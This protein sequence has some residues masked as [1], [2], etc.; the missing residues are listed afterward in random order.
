M[1]P[2]ILPMAGLPP[3]E[4]GSVIEVPGVAETG[5]GLVPDLPHFGRSLAQGPFEIGRSTE[6]VAQLIDRAVLCG[7]VVNTLPGAR[8]TQQLLGKLARTTWFRGFLKRYWESADADIPSAN[9]DIVVAS[10]GLS[11][12]NGLDKSDAPTLFVTGFKELPFVCHWAAAL[13][14]PTPNGV[15]R[16]AIGMRHDWP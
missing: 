1:V 8:V 15:E 10:A 2:I 12:P 7:S 5:W 9:A 13:A 6:A 3:V 14:R 4:A 16:V 11:L